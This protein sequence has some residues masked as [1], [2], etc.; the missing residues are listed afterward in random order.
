M[1]EQDHVD[2]RLVCM[3]R[4][5]ILGIVVVARHAVALVILR[6]FEQGHADAHHDRAFHLVAGSERVDD[7]PHIDRAHDPGDAQ[8]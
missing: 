4:N 8:P 6:G 2:L 1:V 5:G 7:P 3:D